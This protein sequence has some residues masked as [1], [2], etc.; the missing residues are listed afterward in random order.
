MHFLCWWSEVWGSLGLV[1]MV[2]PTQ[3]MAMTLSLG[4]V[5]LGE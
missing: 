3:K 4:L 2:E 1:D 5:F